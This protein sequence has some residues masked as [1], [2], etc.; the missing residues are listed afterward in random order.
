[1]GC[2]GKGA[3]VHIVDDGAGALV[4]ALTAAVDGCYVL[5]A[6]L[7]QCVHSVQEAL[8]A[9]G[10]LVSIN[11]LVSAHFLDLGHVHGHAVCGHAQGVLVVVA[12]VV[13]AGRLHRLVDV[14]LGIV[15]PQ[16]VQRSHNALG[17]PVGHQTLGAFHDQIGCAAAL[18]GGVH[19]IVAVGVVQILHGHL[20]VGVL[21]VEAGDQVLDSL[22]IAPAADGVC[23]QLD[24]CA[25]AGCTCSS[26]GSGRGSSSAGGGG[27]A[28][29]GQRTG[30]AQNTGSLQEGTAGNAVFHGR[31]SL[32]IFFDPSGDRTP[33]CS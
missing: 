12:L 17:T 13:A 9:P 27:T 30:S 25:G 1:M 8:G 18:D 24:A 4:A 20:D 28:A 21:C 29:G 33:F 5:V 3:A 15:G 22:V 26:R 31:F 11:V 32:F 2:I 23:P 19:L 16:I 10:V 6:A 7:V 14:L